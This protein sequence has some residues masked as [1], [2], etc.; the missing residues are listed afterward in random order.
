[1]EGQINSFFYERLLSSQNKEKVSEEIQKFE[2]AKIPEIIISDS[3]ILEFQG[4]SP[5]DDF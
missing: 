2:P 4:L 3:Y 5:N 1:M